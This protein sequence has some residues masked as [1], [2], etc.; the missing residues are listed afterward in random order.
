MFE[1]CWSRE[2]V[3]W[4]DAALLNLCTQVGVDGHEF[5]GGIAQP[6][7]REQLKASPEEVI[8][9][10]GFGAGFGSSTIFLDEMYFGND[11]LSLVKTAILRSPP[12]QPYTNGVSLFHE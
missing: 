10:G 11:R 6:A 7:I 12:H 1:A 9:R 2:Q 5:P 4:Q 3:I 8:R